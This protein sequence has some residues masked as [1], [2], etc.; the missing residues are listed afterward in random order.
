[1]FSFSFQLQ[2][3]E[4]SSDAFSED[5]GSEVIQ[6]DDEE[7]TERRPSRPPSRRPSRPSSRQPT[8]EEAAGG[9]FSDLARSLKEHID[10]RKV[11][12]ASPQE[13][14]LD[15]AFAYGK[16]VIMALPE[17]QWRD[18]ADD[19]TL[20]VL[21]WAKES[22]VRSA[23]N[24]GQSFV[25]PPPLSQHFQAAPPSQYA[26][27][28]HYPQ[29]PSQQFMPLSPSTFMTPSPSVPSASGSTTA[30]QTTSTTSA[31]DMPPLTPRTQEIVN[32]LNADA[33]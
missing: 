32:V 11:P 9:E 14:H 16:S 28:Y 24:Y 4:I 12:A 26:M 10:Q 7:Q 33:C 6:V 17:N 5:E 2:D 3:P 30:L 20:W 23:N 31:A 8:Q 18:A 19:F 15:T 1:M 27:P 21:K 22:R 13:R 29:V 25:T